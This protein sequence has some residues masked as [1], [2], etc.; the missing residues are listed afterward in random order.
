MRLDQGLEAEVERPVD[1]ASKG[2]PRLEDREEE[3]GI[4]AGGAEHIELAGV[5]DELLRQHRHADRGVDGGE[6]VDGA[7]EPMRLA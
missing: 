7:A 4:G 2:A 3:H 1:E 6:I 5:D